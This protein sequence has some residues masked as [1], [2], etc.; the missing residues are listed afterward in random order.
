MKTDSEEIDEVDKRWKQT[1]WM[2]MVMVVV[3]F[4]IFLYTL[5]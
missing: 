2:F 5:F 4:I 1:I 3:F